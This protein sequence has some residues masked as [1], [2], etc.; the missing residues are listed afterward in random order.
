M[1]RIN[2]QEPFVRYALLLAF[3]L[4][5]PR[6]SQAQT[7][8]VLFD[9]P[10]YENPSSPVVMDAQ[11]NLYGTTM[12]DFHNRG[13]VYKLT[14]PAAPDGRW[15]ATT[16]HV[17][18]NGGNF[19]SP[20]GN[21]VLD[22]AGDLFGSAAGINSGIVYEITAA[23]EEKIVYTF[24]GGADDPPP[25]SLIQDSAGNFY[26]NA[27]GGITGYGTLLKLTADGAKQILYSFHG[28]SDGERPNSPLLLDAQGNIYGT[29]LYGGPNHAGTMFKL[30]T[31]GTFTTLY[32][33]G[34][35]KIDALY[36]YAGLIFDSQGNLYGTSGYGGAN[37][38]GTVFELT[39]ANT[40]KILYSFKGGHKDGQLPEASL[41]FDPQGNLYGTTSDNPNAEGPFGTVF[42]LTAQG[43]EIVLHSFTGAPD[44]FNPVT[45][46]IMDQRGNLYGT[47][48]GGYIAYAGGTVFEVAP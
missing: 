34:N 43:E 8:H 31:D 14:P 2:K 40:L 13:T 26:A 36:P 21:M 5:V 7:E 20:V 1:T 45:T 9:T 11:G 44:G 32:A 48:Q 47:T 15:S 42:E 3:C 29:T 41:I 33:F 4:I 38:Y 35:G 22:K 16:L 18:P 37:D 39:T 46:L 25:L 17:F 27:G 30:A 19:E 12:A 23:G 28:A 10:V 6:A 24:S